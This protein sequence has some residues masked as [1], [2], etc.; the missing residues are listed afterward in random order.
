MK[1]NNRIVVFALLKPWEGSWRSARAR[2]AP[3]VQASQHGAARCSPSS[4]RSSAT[5]VLSLRSRA[6]A[7][8]A[9]S[10]AAQP[11]SSSPGA[12]SSSLSALQ[13][14]QKEEQTYKGQETRT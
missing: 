8:R 1:N 12:S 13:K 6:A 5:R 3:R 14:Q 2:G 7:R 4:R 11:G 9:S 10:A